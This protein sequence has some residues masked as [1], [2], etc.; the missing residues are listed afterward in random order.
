MIFENVVIV[1][2][3]LIDNAHLKLKLDCDFEMFIKDL[4][5]KLFTESKKG[6]NS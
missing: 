1:V 4:H 2:V 6:I 5:R 3:Y